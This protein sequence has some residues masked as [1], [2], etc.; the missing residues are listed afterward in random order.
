MAVDTTDVLLRVR[1][2]AALR[3]ALAAYDDSDRQLLVRRL[4]DGNVSI[5]TGHR[6]DEPDAEYTVRC[7]LWAHFG[8]ALADVHDDPR[9]IFVYPA[10]ARP[11]AMTY[12]GIIEELGARGRFV[13]PRR[14]TDEERA[15]RERAIAA[16]I[17][18]A[19][20]SQRVPVPDVPSA[21]PLEGF[22]AVLSGIVGRDLTPELAAVRERVSGSDRPRE[23]E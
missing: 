13:D 17:R 1:D 15:E 7:W 12:D 22:S 19:R 2:E 11:E 21:P 23:N 10:D 6:I 5:F 18:E 4:A 20:D 16:L 8:V 9:G 3:E 14:P